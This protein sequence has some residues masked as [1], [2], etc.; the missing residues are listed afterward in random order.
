MH[1][2]H[3]QY[4]SKCIRP[5]HI[6]IIY[7]YLKVQNSLFFGR[8]FVSLVPVS[9]SKWLNGPCYVKFELRS[10]ILE[11]KKS[12]KRAIIHDSTTFGY[13]VMNKSNS[14]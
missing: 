5:Q 9:M 12:A 3:I 2:L 13:E 10:G 6:N 4:S 14:G 11:I 1:F 8:V 7:F